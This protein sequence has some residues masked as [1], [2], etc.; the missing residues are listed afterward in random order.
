MQIVFAQDEETGQ[1]HAYSELY[2]GKKDSPMIEDLKGWIKE[3]YGVPTIPG[4]RLAGD[5][6][7]LNLDYN[8]TYPG[9]HF[10]DAD[11]TRVTRQTVWEAGNKTSPKIVPIIDT[12]N[13]LSRWKVLR[14]GFGSKGEISLV[15]ARRGKAINLSYDLKDNGFVGISDEVDPKLLSEVKGLNL[16]YLLSDEQSTLEI[17]LEQDDGA[18]FKSSQAI[19]GGKGSWSAIQTLFEDFQAND[20]SLSLHKLDPSRARRL[21]IRIINDQRAGDR[22]GPGFVILDDIRGVMNV[23]KGSPWA[24]AEEDK[25]ERIALDL[26]SKSQMVLESKSTDFLIKSVLLAVESL[27]RK[28][29]LQGDIAIHRGLA[30][31]PGPIARLKHND[32]VKAL[33]FLGLRFTP[34]RCVASPIRQC[35]VP[36]QL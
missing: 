23:P 4:L 21:E 2:L 14:D 16:S 10:F 33:A 29:T 20:A 22:T 25:N 15:P 11:G 8:S 36:Y 9:G 24:R 34:G 5:E 32:S 6:I 7:W 18:V 1:G 27:K 17:R 28:E 13:N 26:A 30:S 31:L 35:L 19:S 12:M 3:K